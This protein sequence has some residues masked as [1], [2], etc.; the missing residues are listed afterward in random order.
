MTILIY[1]NFLLLQIIHT[2][3]TKKV[4][5][6]IHFLS[7]LIIKPFLISKREKSRINKGNNIKKTPNILLHNLI[8]LNVIEAYIHHIILIKTK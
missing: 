8:F 5:K 4:C 3:T 1:Y 7:A 6:Y 2:T